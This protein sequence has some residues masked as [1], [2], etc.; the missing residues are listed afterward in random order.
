M[1]ETEREEPEMEVL[2]VKLD[3]L[4]DILPADYR[5]DFIKLDVEGGEFDVL[6]GARRTLQ[7]HRPHVIFEFGLGASD[8][9]M[10]KPE[11]FFDF[12]ER[13][14]YGIF[15]LQEFL[16]RGRRLSREGF[17]KTYSENSEYYFIAVPLQNRT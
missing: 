15:L 11:E 8:H 9:Y 2:Q 7:R 5:V 10:V 17:L 6:K 14:D 4:D 13:E 16:G 1:I 12:M 3:T